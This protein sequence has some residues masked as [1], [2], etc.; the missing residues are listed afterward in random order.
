MYSGILV[1]KE[2]RQMEKKRSY[3]VRMAEETHRK[4]RLFAFRQDKTMSTVVNDAVEK[5]LQRKGR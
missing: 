2:V 4:L 5:Y 1:T 3:M